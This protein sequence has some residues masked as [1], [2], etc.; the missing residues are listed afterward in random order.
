MSEEKPSDYE[1]GQKVYVHA[2]GHWYEG[3]VKKIGRTKVHIEYTSGTGKTRVKPCSLDQISLE[4]LEG[5][6]SGHGRRKAERNQ[7]DRDRYG[8]VMIQT[9]IDL[10][11]MN[12]V[13]LLAAFQVLAWPSGFYRGTTHKRARDLIEEI[14]HIRLKR[15]ANPPREAW[16]LEE[17]LEWAA[18]PDLQN[19]ADGP[20]LEEGLHI[21]QV[22]KPGEEKDLPPGTPFMIDRGEPEERG[23]GI[24]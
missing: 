8:P 10:S 5:E 23:M 18:N 3:E 19:E 6:R 15:N 24:G 13:R 9:Q 14:A 7:R 4:K 20:G 17:Y 12:G 22:V 16:G 21:V 11:G 1:V 2:Y